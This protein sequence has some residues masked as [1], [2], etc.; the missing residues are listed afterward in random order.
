MRVLLEV[1]RLF[2]HMVGITTPEKKDERKFFFLWVGVIL[3]ILTV[4]V[5]FV[6]LIVQFVFH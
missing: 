2:H 1:M 4:G 6:I 5:L 3:G